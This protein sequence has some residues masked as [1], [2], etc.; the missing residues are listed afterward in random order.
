[1]IKG[2]MTVLEIVERYPE[3]EDIFR[4]YDDII[5]EC[6]LC[7]CLFDSLK[8]ISYKHNLNLDSLV[9]KLNSVI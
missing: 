9:D 4:S 8:E 6:I 7:H 5:G 2:E 3:T 1:M